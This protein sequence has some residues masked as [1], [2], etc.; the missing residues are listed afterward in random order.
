MSCC[1]HV[2]ASLLHWLLFYKPDFKCCY[3]MVFITDAVVGVV[4]QCVS[5]NRCVLRAGFIEFV[6][7]TRCHDNQNSHFYR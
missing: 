2:F 1:L 5:G 6:C 7:L 3:A 4:T